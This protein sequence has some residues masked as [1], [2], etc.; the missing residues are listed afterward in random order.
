MISLTHSGLRRCCRMTPRQ[1]LRHIPRS[2]MQVL[3]ASKPPA[4]RRVA[5]V[6]K[7]SVSPV[8][9]RDRL[10]LLSVELAK[11]AR[12]E[13]SS[14][15][16]IAA[17]LGPYGAILHDGSEYRGDYGVAAIVL[18]DFHEKRLDL[19]ATS[20]ADVLALETIPSFLEA[21]ILAELLR[22]Y[23]MPAWVSF[24][25]RDAG[26]HLRWHTD[27]KSCGAIQQSPGCEC[28]RG[29]LHTAAV[30]PGTDSEHLHCSARQAG[31]GVPE[32]R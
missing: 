15:V 9:R 25:C 11:R 18:R 13:L 2:S 27:R 30:P 24:S 32:F 17:S 28:P 14:G 4:T 23:E 26:T 31:A 29:Q 20:G 10:M 5:R 22:N 19:F 3:S 21:Q 7:R 16:V 1:L 12:D 6:S 8:P